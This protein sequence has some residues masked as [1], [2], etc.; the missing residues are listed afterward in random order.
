MHTYT[1]HHVSLPSTIQIY[2][3]KL[4]YVQEK[5]VAS[6]PNHKQFTLIDKG[7]FFPVKRL[8]AYF[9]D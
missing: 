9:S 5:E 8:F 2:L 7:K 6:L 1:V 3:L 4:G